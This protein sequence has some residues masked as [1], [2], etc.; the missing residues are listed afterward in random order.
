M[1]SRE[2]S[3][4]V[5]SFSLD[6]S[7][8]VVELVHKIKR[9]VQGRAL[10]HIVSFMH[11]TVLVQNLKKELEKA[12]TD[13]KIVL[14]KHSEKRSTHVRLYTLDRSIDALEL[15]DT[16]LN[17]LSIATKSKDESIQSYRKQLL[18]RYF[19]DN[20]TGLPNLYQLRKDL[21]SDEER[22]LVLIKIDNFQTINTFY[23]FVVGDYVIES[24]AEHLKKSIP[25]HKVYRLS[26]SEYALT[27]QRSKGFYALKEFLEELY[28]K[29][30]KIELN[31]QE[32]KIYVDFTLASSSYRDNENIFSKVSMAL[33]YAKERGLPFWIYEDRMNFENEYQKNLELSFM[34][35][36][37]LTQGRIIPYFQAIVENTQSKVIK[38]E[39]LARLI[40]R[41][42]KLIS[43]L[44]FIPIAKKIK[45]YNEVTKQI[46][47]KSFAAFEELEYEFSINL[48]IEDIMSA[49]IFAFILEK[50][51]SSQAANRVTFEILES[52]AI[53]DFKKVDRF[54]NEVRRHG[55]KVAIDDFGSGYSNFFYLTKM[56]VDY[57]KI[58]GSLIEHIDIDSASCLVVETI[59][60]F[61]KKLGVEIVAEYVHSS[62]VMD[63]VRALGIEYSQG[64]YIDEPSLTPIANP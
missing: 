46:I 31:Y 48:S 55:A 47:N 39:S 30:T 28:K 11:N 64:F 2:S 17:E 58:D 35:R 45:V 54:I 53:Q 12:L 61:A 25:E 14:L 41:D 23:G 36:D 50:L 20:L 15:S 18:M 27:L 22:G 34:V 56:R 1:S 63:K 9:L 16:L 51:R 62:V 49:E 42:D 38:Y 6:S 4:E 37:A 57:I 13:A 3:L 32:S 59:V 5:Q 43:P 52:E 40:D 7:S 21:E 33:R 8:E 29:I 26:G 19:T 10:I 44:I 60:D 24:V